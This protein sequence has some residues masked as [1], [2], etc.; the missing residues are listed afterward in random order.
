MII[1]GRVG[2][3]VE[4]RKTSFELFSEVSL[5]LVMYH[6]ICFTPFVPDVQV[7]FYLGYSVCAVICFHLLISFGLL[8]N[9]NRGELRIRY[10]KWKGKREY[11]ASRKALK[12]F[13][14][15]RKVIRQEARKQKREEMKRKMESRGL[16]RYEESKEE[17]PE[18]SQSSASLSAIEEEKSEEES[19]STF[20]SATSS[21][22]KRTII[23][24]Q[25]MR[26]EQEKKQIEN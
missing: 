7:R 22:I 18:S 11:T 24:L 15:E 4:K 25:E 21:E 9:W 17:E 19:G 5:M 20:R 12:K 16:P 13:W 23:G 14:K 6:M 26:E 2:P 8:A 3:F 10:I 1:L